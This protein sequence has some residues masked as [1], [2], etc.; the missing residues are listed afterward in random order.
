MADPYL[1]EI[2]LFGFGF[3]PHNYAFCAGQTI[4]IQQNA[5]L[6]SLLGVNF[7]GN[8]TTTYMLPNLVSR[9]AGGNGSGP[10]LSPRHIGDTDGA[11]AVSLTTQEI[12]PHSHTMQ[13]YLPDSGLVVTPTQN[14]AIGYIN[15]GSIFASAAANAT[16]NAA[17]ISIAGGS[18]PHPNVQP[19]VGLNYSIALVGQFPSFS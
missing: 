15:Q 19:F 13:E 7:G 5:A 14:S 6:F 2:E 3:A 1:G 10:G 8:G 12:P 4:A 11:Q 17:A 18:V 16:M 9:F